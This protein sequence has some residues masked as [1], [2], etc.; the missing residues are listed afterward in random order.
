LRKDNR[1][2][3]R[4]KI[5]KVGQALGFVQVADES[6]IK[7][8]STNSRILSNMRGPSTED[9]QGLNSFYTIGKPG[10]LIPGYTAQTNDS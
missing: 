2:A 6:V 7:T 1:A 3:E 4:K 5:T 9:N 10:E 8:G